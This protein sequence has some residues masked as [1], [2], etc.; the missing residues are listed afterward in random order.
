MTFDTRD[1]QESELRES[2]FIDEITLR[3]GYL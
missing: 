3:I 1:V 2:R